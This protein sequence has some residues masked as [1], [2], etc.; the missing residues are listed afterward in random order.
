MQGKGFRHRNR[1]VYSIYGEH[2]F[3][4]FESLVVIDDGSEVSIQEEK[5]NK[6][7]P[8]DG[9]WEVVSSSENSLTLDFCDYY[10]DGE[11]I[12]KNGYVLNILNRALKLK[13]PVRLK[14]EYFVNMEYIPQRLYLATETPEIFDIY[15]NGNKIDKIDCGYF[16]DTAFRKI[17]ISRHLIIGENS[18]VF[19][20]LL[21][22]SDEVYENLEKSYMLKVKN[23]LTYDMEVEPVY[24]VGD[25]AVKTD[26]V[27]KNW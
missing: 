5:N 20:T 6:T 4:K 17:E 9:S 7:L 16:I 23:K 13:R 18:I 25:F 2:T 14:C 10:F 24:L 27:L 3:G 26:G 12:E 19:E 11:L 15:V 21:K 1:R 8:I 22:Q